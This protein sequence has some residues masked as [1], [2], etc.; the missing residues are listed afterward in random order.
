MYHN[1][2]TKDSPI[3]SIITPLWNEESQ[4]PKLAASLQRLF[5]AEGIRWQWIAVDDGSEDGTAS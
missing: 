1:L 2:K 4:I 3:V 5:S